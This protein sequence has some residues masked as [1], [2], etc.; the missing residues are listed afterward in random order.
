[1]KNLL[2]IVS[3]ISLA[4]C[5]GFKEYWKGEP[6]EKVSEKKSSQKK[7]SS[8]DALLR[9]YVGAAAALLKSEGQTKAFKA[10]ATPTW[11][12][13]PTYVFVADFKG[14]I[15]FNVNKDYPNGSNVYNEKD[16]NGKFFVQEMIQIAKTTGNGFVE[17]RI[18]NPATGKVEPKRSFIKTV[19]LNNPQQ[20]KLIVGS[21]YYYESNTPMVPISQ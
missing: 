15:Y 19:V 10:F 16:S 2:I 4:S 13:S 21:G 11:F 17:Y 7:S 14:V 18:K 12:Q 3:L 6:S 5:E 8:R 1:M 20:T 9:K